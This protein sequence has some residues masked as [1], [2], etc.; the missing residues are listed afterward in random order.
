MP[1]TFQKLP[2]P[3]DTTTKFDFDFESEQSLAIL[4]TYTTHEIEENRTIEIVEL[5]LSPEELFFNAIK[6]NN[7][8]TLKI[9]ITKHGIDLNKTTN[10]KG[11]NAL[12]LAARHGSIYIVRYLVQEKAID[13]FSI[14]D[15]DDE[16]TALHIAAKNGHTAI[17]ILLL[18]L[19]VNPDIEDN[20]N[21][22]PLHYAAREGHFNV[23][24]ALIRKNADINK[25]NEF[26]ET[27]KDLALKG[28]S[29]VEQ[30]L[31]GVH[32]NNPF[33]HLTQKYKKFLATHSLFSTEK[34]H[35]TYQESNSYSI[36]ILQ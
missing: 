6:N 1:D 3:M 17:V 2:I 11:E 31:Q 23:V 28:K 32:N 24:K 21:E 8:T 33:D 36:S 4:S 27:P 7:L 22:T 9:I 5:P 19:G 34:T 25:K 30:R 16:C 26:D 15:N 13:I 20:Y 35:P 12:H 18:N 10:D 14:T 29:N